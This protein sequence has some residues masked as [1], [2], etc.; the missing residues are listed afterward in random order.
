MFPIASVVLLNNWVQ[1][2]EGFSELEKVA[3]AVV[4]AVIFINIVTCTYAVKAMKNPENYEVDPPL[5]LKLK[6]NWFI[7][8]A[9]ISCLCFYF[10]AIR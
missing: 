10:I 5:K 7:R 2:K 6:K 8:T 3:I 9:I 4:P 1:D